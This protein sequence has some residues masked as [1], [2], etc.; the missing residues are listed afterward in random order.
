MF[1]SLDPHLSRRPP[2]HNAPGSAI[3]THQVCTLP[4]ALALQLERARRLAA[5]YAAAALQ[6]R[7]KL[8]LH[9]ALDAPKVA[10]PAVDAAGR[11]TLALDFGRFIIKSGGGRRRERRA[12][13][14]SPALVPGAKPSAA[15]GH[16]LAR[17]T[18]AYI[19]RG[20]FQTQPG[21]SAAACPQ[22]S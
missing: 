1:L 16:D 20:I 9:L 17:A 10:I 8:R 4:P 3:L 13:G 19:F 15:G 11:A 18:D 6:S 14:Q 2:A 21:Q 5:Q 7:P 22:P 12:F